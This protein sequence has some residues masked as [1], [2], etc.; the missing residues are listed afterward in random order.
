[1]GP[2]F[3]SMNVL[4][5]ISEDNGELFRQVFKDKVL[6][7][8]FEDVV[9]RDPSLLFGGCTN[10]RLYSEIVK[11]FDTKGVAIF[12]SSILSQFVSQQDGNDG[13]VEK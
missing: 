11:E 13:A 1:M 7:Y 9:R 2:F 6:M 5:T 4:G 12:H 3:I 8:L 10:S